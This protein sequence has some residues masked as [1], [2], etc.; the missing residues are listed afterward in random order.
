MRGSPV[1]QKIHFESGG[2]SCAA[3]YYP[4]NNGACVVMAGGFGVTKEP[5][6][7]R[8]AARF[9]AAGYGALAFDYRR[10][11]ESDGALRQVLPLD[12]QLAD[13][14]A[15]IARA[16]TLQ[17]VDP[18][19]IA[20]WG[21][22]LSGGHLLRL[23][24]ES[25]GFA[26]VIAQTPYAGGLAAARAASRHQTP[27]AMARL[28]GIGLLDV[29]G[30]LLDR[31][32]RLVPLAAPRG[33]VA[34]LTTPDAQEGA[35]ALDPNNDYPEWIQEVAARSVLRTATYRPGRYAARI[36]EPLLVV[37]CDDDVAALAA[38]AVRVARR[39]PRGE[40]A[41]FPG[42]HYAPF[43]DAHDSVVEAELHFL[44]R[45]LSPTPAVERAGDHAGDV[46]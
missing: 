39:A 27:W 20:L 12:D 46:A 36:D 35:A 4:G 42:S 34:V 44:D 22:S 33:T 5:A 23:A 37:V 14:R 40:L 2:I 11:G 32:P 7:D 28:M 29:A 19:R 38:S 9:Q 41:R 8:F 31:A 45:H 10:I 25:D 17:A 43:L 18:T 24:A 30:G 1:R 26:A 15:A 3:W 21:W 6:T 13:W 16:S